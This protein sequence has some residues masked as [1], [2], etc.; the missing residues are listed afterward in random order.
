MPEQLKPVEVPECVLHIW[1][2]F[3]QMSPKRTNGM[4]V[5]PITSLEIEAWCRLHE[6]QITP[7]EVQALEA[8][9]ST[10]VSSSDKVQK[11]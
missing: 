10:Y 2:W 8:I 9:D 11:K 4:G 1:D 7:F 3:A 6:V 5:A